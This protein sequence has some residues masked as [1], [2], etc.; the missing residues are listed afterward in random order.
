MFLTMND[1]QR[2]EAVQA[3]MDGRITVEQARCVLH[4]SERQ[5]YRLLHSI[6]TDGIPGLIHKGRGRPSHRKL[7]DEV[8][9]KIISLVRDK[10][11]D[12]NDTH[13]REIL[14]GRY[15][16]HIGRE[17]LRSLLRKEG[18]PPKRKRR[19]PRYRKRRERKEAFG[20][21]LQIDASPHP[22]LETR[23]PS[24]TLVGAIDDATGYVWARFEEAETTWAYLDLLLDI[25]T[26][27]GLPL[28][29]YSDRHTIF[30]SPRPPNIVEQLKNIK[31]LTHFGRA[32]H[33]LGITI[34]KA[35][36]PQAKGRIE[37]LWETLQDRLVVELRLANAQNLLEAN[38]VIKNVLKDFNQHFTV[39][40]K[41]KQGVFRKA[42]SLSNLERILCLKE[43]RTVNNDHTI[44]FEGI[45][46]QIPPSK[47]FHSIT[48]K[49]V[50][51]LQLRDGSIE[52][53]YK[54]MTVAQF[55]PQAVSRLINTVL[56]EKTNLRKA[57]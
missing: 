3:I 49:R 19:S 44:S 30:H 50:E 25:S 36:S 28:S 11:Q 16:I 15:H 14:D 34:I 26:S 4:R 52:I 20:M 12:I 18:I 39:L 40:P 6:R 7:S 41:Q 23:A 27:H 35:Y 46:L 10:L 1:R 47:N 48:G 55:S 31:P 51:V 29:L 38:Q 42:P 37:R 33:D 57:A 56:A 45:A 54:D 17:T 24:L 9:L 8:R 21:M 43:S 5:V 2:I 53:V 22:W 13:L 32:M